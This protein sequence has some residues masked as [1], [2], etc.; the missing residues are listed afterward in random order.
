MLNRKLEQTVSGWLE[1]TVTLSPDDGIIVALSGGADSVSLLSALDRLRKDGTLPPE[2]S[3]L[4]AH[5]N[6]GLRGEE[7]DRDER[8]VRRLCEEMQIPLQVLKVNVAEQRLKGEGIEEAGRR[9][10]YG[11]FR[12]LQQQYGYRYVATAHTADDQLETVLLNLTRGS[13]LNGLCG[14]PPVRDGIIRPLLDCSRE[15]IER[16]CEENH[17]SFVTDSTNTDTA[18][19]RNQIRQTVLPLLRDINPQITSACSRLTD[20]LREDEALLSRLTRELL[21][22]ARRPDG[23]YDRDLLLFAPPALLRRA[24]KGVME[25]AGGD[26]EERHIRLVEQMLRAGEGV[27]Q[28]PGEVTVTVKDDLLL[29]A[30]R[31]ARPEK[32][33]YFEYPVEPGVTLTIGGKTYTA[34]CVTRENFENT[35]KV[36][37][38]VLKFALD[39]DKITNGLIVRQRKMGDAFHPVGGAGK[40]LKKYF[41]EQKIPTEQRAFIPILCDDDGVVLITG[42]SCDHRVRLDE[43]TKRI[44]LFYPAETY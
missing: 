4:A 42:F 39:Y 17:L 40:T 25:T 27:L 18:Y 34:R 13:G 1:R 41:Q 8:F 3:L 22:S 11:F 36:Y 30:S 14:I 21:Q 33:P 29:A 38:N 32:L 43:Q 23:Q 5:V 6:H 24:I 20:S 10:R 31:P 12:R 44:L 37:K 16:Y 15:E 26:P 19:R 28:I 7:A 35:R 2:L 9:I